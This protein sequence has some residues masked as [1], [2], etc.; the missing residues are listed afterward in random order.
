MKFKAIIFDMDG[1]LI[2]S[3]PLHKEVEQQILCELGVKLPHEEH[4]K[5]AGVG[6]EMWSIIKKQYGYNKDVSENDIHATKR[7]L[8]LERLTSNPIRP[9]DGVR[10]IIHFAQNRNLKIA[11][12]SSSSRDNIEIVARAIEISDKVEIIVSGDEVPKTKPS[13]DIFLETSRLL[14]LAPEQCIVIEDSA[15]GVKAAKDAGMFCIG[16]ANPNSGDQDLSLADE[17]VYK[18][19]DCIKSIE[20]KDLI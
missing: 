8:Y 18:L 19:T 15:N 12:A 4:I 6:K 10:D 2:D 3:E 5:F 13:P 7:Q 14:N 11:I 17:I 1:V 20:N 16:F 9:I